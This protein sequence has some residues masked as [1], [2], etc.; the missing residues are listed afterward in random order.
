M[1]SNKQESDRGRLDVNRDLPEESEAV[2]ARRDSI[3][4]GDEALFDVEVSTSP[5]NTPRH[6]HAATA[7]FF[8]GHD[9]H[10]L[11]G[12]PFHAEVPA[13]HV[14]NLELGVLPH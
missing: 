6:I 13:S 2:V 8:V 4:H 11:V 10:F 9:H 1:A 5:A 14:D 12:A 7:G 3:I